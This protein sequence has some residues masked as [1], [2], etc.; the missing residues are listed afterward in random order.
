M[1][2]KDITDRQVCEV[3][4]LMARERLHTGHLTMLGLLSDMTG[5]PEKVCWRAMERTC[6]RDLIDYGSSLNGA[7]LTPKGLALLATA[8]PAR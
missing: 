8:P 6:R 1:S 4:E 5:Q 7:F 3:V 2:V